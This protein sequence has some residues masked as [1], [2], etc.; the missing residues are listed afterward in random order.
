MFLGGLLQSQLLF[1]GLETQPL[2]GVPQEIT[3]EQGNHIIINAFVMGFANKR[4]IE[5]SLVTYLNL[6]F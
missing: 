2:A 1:Q 6:T 5:L 4:P 3:L